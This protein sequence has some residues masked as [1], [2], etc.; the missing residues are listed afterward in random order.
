MSSSSARPKTNVETL[1]EVV[2][3]PASA[4]MPLPPL[5]ETLV[6]APA[7]AVGEA[8][9]PSVRLQPGLHGGFVDAHDARD[10]SLRVTLMDGRRTRAALASHV[11]PDLV[12]QC[13]TQRSMVLLSD[14]DPPCVVGA[15]QTAPSPVVESGGAVSIAAD[16]IHLRANQE[17]RL[18]AGVNTV[19]IEMGD[20][21]KVRL[22]C[23][24][25]IFDVAA[26]LRIYSALVELP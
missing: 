17:L 13:I 14:G 8:E 5:L 22:R 26:N 4:P 7:S 16:R 11:H 9:V 15:L 3:L 1:E 23:E 6:D 18:E 24:R 25:G 12:T 20:D 10:G 21:G 2:E 19:L